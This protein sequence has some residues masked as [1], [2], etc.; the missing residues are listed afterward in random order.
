MALMYLKMGLSQGTDR[1]GPTAVLPATR[2]AQFFWG[3]EVETKDDVE[4]MSETRCT[5][6]AP[7]CLSNQWEN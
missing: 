3:R 2:C 4:C 7:F 1:T 5:E 6:A